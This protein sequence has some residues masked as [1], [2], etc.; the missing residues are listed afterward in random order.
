MRPLIEAI[1][2]INKLKA[3]QNEMA[4]GSF[5]HPNDSRYQHNTGIYA[6]LS[7]AIEVIEEAAKAEE[8][9]DK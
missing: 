1:P 7:Q 3:K 8:E 4:H 9:D 5:R 2:V 6:G